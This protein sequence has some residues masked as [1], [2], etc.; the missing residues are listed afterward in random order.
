M[1]KKLKKIGFKHDL[2]FF[3]HKSFFLFKN[4]FLKRKKNKFLFLLCPPYSGSTLLTQI[5][6]SSKNVSCNNYIATMEGQLIPEVRSIMFTS[7]RWDSKSKYP[8]K[9][10]KSTWLKY[11]DLNKKILVDKTTTN[12]IRVDEIKKTFKN[13]YFIC[14]VRNP[15]ALIEGIMRRNSKDICFATKFTIKVL[16]QQMINI[17]NNK[18]NLIW[19]KYSEMCDKKIETK[20]KI[21]FF[22]KELSDLDFERF[23]SA[24]NF[25]NKPLKITNLNKEKIGKLNRKELYTI[26][27]FLKKEKQLLEFFNFKI[28]E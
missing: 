8:W 10:I 6:T 21:K 16:K 12:I 27:R 25:K 19:F 20:E 28:I 2:Y 1:K 15:Y 11:W 7:N 5:I 14:L 18:K 13:C 17:N 26:N 3:T 9:M 22:L 4:F 23:Y 24:H